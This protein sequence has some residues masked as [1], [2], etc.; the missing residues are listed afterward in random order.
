[1]TFQKNFQIVSNYSKNQSFQQF[2][3]IHTIHIFHSNFI[4]WNKKRQNKRELR[5]NRR[6]YFRK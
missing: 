5:L 2:N 3:F 4:L 1:M 6:K